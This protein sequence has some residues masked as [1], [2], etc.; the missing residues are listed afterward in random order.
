[1]AGTPKL[2][3]KKYFG[4]STLEQTTI[5]LDEAQGYLGYFWTKEGSS[6]IVVSIGGQ[7]IKSFD[8]LKAIANQDCYKNTGLIEVGLFLSNEGKHSIWEKA[9]AKE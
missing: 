4:S 8:E 6:N 2:S 5:N 3:I 9:P 7:P 1:M